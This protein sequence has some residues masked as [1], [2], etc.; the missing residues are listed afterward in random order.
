[1]TLS[2][3]ETNGD[4]DV[5]QTPKLSTLNGHDASLTIGSTV[6]YSVRTQNVSNSLTP[7]TTVTEQFNSVQANLGITIKPVV[8]GDDQV[9]LTIDVSFTDFI[10]K[11]PAS[12]PPPSST[13]Q[14]KSI[15]RVRNEEMI[16]LGGLERLEKSENTSGTPILSRIPVLRWLFSSR[17]K[18]KNKLVSVVFIK[19]TIIY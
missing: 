16:V 2:A 18:T 15:I 14:F 7:I 12:G 8:S 3:L 11:A 9:T 4:A 10:G 5:R 17:E 6:Y 1:M 19:P 13:S